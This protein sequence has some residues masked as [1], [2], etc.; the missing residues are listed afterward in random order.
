MK[1]IEKDLKR[2]YVK[3]L[4][5]TEE[6]L[7]ILYNIIT[8]GD[9]INAKTTRDVKFRESGSS[10]RVPMSLTIR[11]ER[12][13]FQPFT[14]RLRIRGVVVEGPE[15]F[16]VKGKHHTVNITPGKPLT[17]CKDQWPSFI[18]SELE[19]AGLRR[20]RLIIVVLDYD[21]ACIALLSEQGIKILGEYNSGLPGKNE[22]EKFTSL[23]NDYL[24][25][26]S[27]ETVGFIEKHGVKIVVIA[28]PG[29]LARK[30]ADNVKS[31]SK[32][33]DIIV[34]SVSIGGCNGVNEV[35]K[36][37]SVKRALREISIIH[38]RDCLEEFKKYLVKNPL[39]I[40]YGLD[41]VEYAVRSNA[42]EK[43][44]IATDYLRTYDESMRK[45]VYNLLNEASRR[46]AEIIIVPRG[47]DVYIELMGFGGIIAILRYPLS[48]PTDF[49]GDSV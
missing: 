48:R 47:N 12:L 9:L 33:L 15:E 10:R 36:R 20:E 23:L 6:D 14:D 8:P 3:L 32:G 31:R 22:P 39:L 37:D 40:A 30:I 25:K 38:A 17:I 28:S 44:V 49:S 5:E 4:P 34:D 24:T 21:E 29:D 35:L 7:W 11:V 2:G 13:E 46:R 19:K 1:I 27:N 45:R 43:L 42:V 18:L 41:E 26:I 16:G